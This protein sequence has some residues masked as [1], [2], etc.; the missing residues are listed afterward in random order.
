M[1]HILID[2][3]A[4][5]VNVTLCSRNLFHYNRVIESTYY[6]LRDKEDSL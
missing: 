4:F 5:S 1:L 3:V 6:K 2:N